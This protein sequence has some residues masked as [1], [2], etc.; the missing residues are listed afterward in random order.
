MVFKVFVFVI[1]G[2]FVER[3][4]GEV[5][6]VGVMVFGVD[7]LFGV[8]FLCV[9]VLILFVMVDVEFVGWFDL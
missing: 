3:L 5:S 4:G 9:K 1:F 6:G 8:G 7:G 2:W